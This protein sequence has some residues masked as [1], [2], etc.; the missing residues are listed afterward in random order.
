MSRC[1][2]HTS[3]SSRRI[4][5]DLLPRKRQRIAYT[6]RPLFLSVTGIIVA[7]EWNEHG[8]KHSSICINEA[9]CTIYTKISLASKG[10]LESTGPCLGDQDLKMTYLIPSSPLLLPYNFRQALISSSSI[11][12]Y[13]VGSTA[14]IRS[15]TWPRN[16]IVLSS[17]S[18]CHRRLAVSLVVWATSALGYEDVQRWITKHLCHSFSGTSSHSPLNRLLLNLGKVTHIPS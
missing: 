7:I 8:D 4:T 1:I 3:G 14:C 18:C 2:C 6:A 16:R 11:P 13:F 10:A 5:W 15:Y 12:L 17:R 9:L